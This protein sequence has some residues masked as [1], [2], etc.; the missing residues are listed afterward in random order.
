[1]ST[2]TLTKRGSRS[3]A[4]PTSEDV[5]S[6]RDRLRA[7]VARQAK[8]VRRLKI[9]VAA[10]GL[11]TIVIT[12]LWVLNQWEANGAFQHFGSHEGNPGDWNPT[13]W[14]L[15]VG[16]WG[17]VVG[18]MALRVYFERPATV[19]EVDCELPLLKRRR[20][21]KKESTEAELRRL[22]RERLDDIGRLR[23]H[24]AAWVLGMI[25]LTPIWAL[26]EWQDNG[27]LERFSDDGQS[28]SWELWILAIAG[29]WLLVIAAIALQLY[30]RRRVKTWRST[31]RLGA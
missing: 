15:L 20:P 28:G 24:V 5:A 13:L 23:F 7:A 17:L 11:G 8:R 19:V 27:G 1:V 10:W 2:Q 14:A 6:D 31:A 3:P 9:N 22:A 30:L 29:I 18:I 16:V 4:T 26:I 25:V 21:A 12:G